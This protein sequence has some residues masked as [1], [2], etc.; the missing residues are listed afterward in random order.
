MLI[1]KSK[2]SLFEIATRIGQANKD[3]IALGLKVPEDDKRVFCDLAE[4][5]LKVI[6]D[7]YEYLK[8]QEPC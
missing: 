3:L 7:I 6:L 5:N 1:Q 8:S 2:E 4:R